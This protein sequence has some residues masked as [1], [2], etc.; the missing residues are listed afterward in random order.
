[1][2]TREMIR[3]AQK[4]QQNWLQSYEDQRESVV[5]ITSVISSQLKRLRHAE[6]R[7]QLARNHHLSLIEPELQQK[8][9]SQ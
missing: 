5:P 3:L 9:I 8:V 7:L 1:M 2:T 6:H 4:L